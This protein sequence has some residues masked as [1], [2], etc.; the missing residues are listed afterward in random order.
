[1]KVKVEGTPFTPTLRNQSGVYTKHTSHD[2]RRVARKP[3]NA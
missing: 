2:E 1:M 3:D